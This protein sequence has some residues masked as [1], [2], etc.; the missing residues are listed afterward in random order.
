MQWQTLTRQNKSARELSVVGFLL[1]IIQ[2][3]Y[4][5]YAEAFSFG[6][7]CHRQSDNKLPGSVLFQDDKARSQV[8]SR[9]PKYNRAQV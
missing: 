7:S 9:R 5:K 1:K 3:N 6:N 2:K 8:F 4:K